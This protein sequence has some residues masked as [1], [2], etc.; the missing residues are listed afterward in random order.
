VG[1]R[2]SAHVQTGPGAHSP[3]CAISTERKAVVV[4]LTALPHLEQRLKEG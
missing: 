2:F 1:V 4:A 3:S